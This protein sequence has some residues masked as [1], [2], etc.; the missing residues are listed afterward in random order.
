MEGSSPS[1]L[2][3]FSVFSLSLLY[4]ITISSLS[5]GYRKGLQKTAYR[6]RKDKQGYKTTYFTSTEKIIW[7]RSWGFSNALFFHSKDFDY[8]CK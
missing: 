4:R 2:C 3:L 5:I 1:V 7:K 6:Q 8:L